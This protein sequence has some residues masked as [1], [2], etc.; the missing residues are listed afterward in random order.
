MRNKDQNKNLISYSSIYNKLQGGIAKTTI[1]TTRENGNTSFYQ[2]DENGEFSSVKIKVGA[3]Y[4]FKLEGGERN[5][6]QLY[7]ARTPIMND[8]ANFTRY[9]WYN[10]MSVSGA[11]RGGSDKILCHRIKIY[12]PG[13][14]S[15]DYNFFPQGIITSNTFRGRCLAG[16]WGTEY[17]WGNNYIPFNAQ[18]STN[19]N[20]GWSPIIAGGTETPSGYGMRVAFGSISPGVQGWS[21]MVLKMLGDDNKHRAYQFDVSGGLYTWAQVADG[22]WGG[23]Y[24]YAKNPTSDRDLKYDI[25]YTEGRESYDRVMQW[26]PTMFKYKGSDTQ[27]Y[28]LI[29]QDLAKIDLQYVKI[30]PG[31]PIFEDVIGVDEDGNEYVDRQ[32][33]TDRADDTLALDSNVILTDM[34]CAMVYMGNKMNKLEQELEQLKQAVAS[35]TSL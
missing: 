24:D 21:H 7:S 23:N 25:T 11:V 22:S 34:A 30:V 35:L 9:N 18:S 29:A 4:A 17:N 28:G 16:A 13:V 1:R 27:R 3:D 15:Y 33:E 12:S 6:L 2:F 20:G 19:N 8:W 10:D 14:D 26:L 5:D 32:I 31:S